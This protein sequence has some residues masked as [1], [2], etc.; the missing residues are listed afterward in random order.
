MKKVVLLTTMAVVSWMACTIKGSFQGLYITNGIDLKNCLKNKDKA[1]ISIWAPKCKGEFCYSLNA[2]QTKCDLKNTTLF[3]VAE[4]YDS[5]LMQ[6]NYQT[7][8]PIFGID[9]DYYNSN[10][11][12]R[13]LSSFI[14]DVTYQQNL[15]GRFLYFENGV[16]KK[17][18]EAIE[19]I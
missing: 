18:F 7:K 9:V 4:Y 17:S 6:V 3:I 12:S 10:T 16:F 13:Y 19:E 11:T 15:R 1:I 5:D 14:Y 2:L 8:K